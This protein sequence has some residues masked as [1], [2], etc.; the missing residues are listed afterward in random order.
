MFA[1]FTP[2]TLEWNMGGRSVFF[3]SLANHGCQVAF[4]IISSISA[5]LISL[6]PSC[7]LSLAKE[8][9]CIIF[10]CPGRRRSFRKGFSGHI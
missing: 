1:R 9:F 2:F 5:L 7:L 3:S 4:T 8:N 6:N 10:G